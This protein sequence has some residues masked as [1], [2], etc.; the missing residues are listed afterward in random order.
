MGAWT[1]MV[2]WRRI[3]L[4]APLIILSHWL[5][6]SFFTTRVRFDVALG[7]ASTMAGR[8]GKFFTRRVGLSPQLS[9]EK[10]PN[11]RSTLRNVPDLAHRDIA[12]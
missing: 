3:E 6:F 11:G 10:S 8:C 9:F 4:M 2:F 5:S 1:V 7:S 12:R